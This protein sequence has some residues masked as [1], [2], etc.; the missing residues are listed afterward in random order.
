VTA[1]GSWISAA[2]QRRAPPFFAAESCKS[3]C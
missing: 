3:P 1:G 2:E